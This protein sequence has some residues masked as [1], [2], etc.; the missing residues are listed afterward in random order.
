MEED[1]KP[2]LETR[3]SQNK[4]LFSV[5]LEYKKAIV[6]LRFDV[7]YGM[8]HSAF[9]RIDLK[10]GQMERIEASGADCSFFRPHA[11]AI[12]RALEQATIHVK[13]KRLP[14]LTPKGKLKAKPPTEA[15]QNDAM[16]H[17]ATKALTTLAAAAF[18]AATPVPD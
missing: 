9:D 7:V 6:L 14:S 10:L 2:F 12:A 4:F 15:E 18:K 1:I 5:K 13:H 3:V 11:A 8:A 17:A 16:V